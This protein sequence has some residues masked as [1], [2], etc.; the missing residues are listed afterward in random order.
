MR[1]VLRM[2][3]GID[4][5]SHVAGALT[6]RPYDRELLPEHLVGLAQLLGPQRDRLLEL[7]FVPREL[8]GA[9]PVDHR[10]LLGGRTL[11][12]GA[13]QDHRE[14][15]EGDARC[16][17]KR[18]RVVRR[19]A[20]SREGVGARHRRLHGEILAHLGDDGV[21][22][23]AAR[24][25]D[26]AAMEPDKNAPKL[27]SEGQINRRILVIDD[28]REIDEDFAKILWRDMGSTAVLAEAEA[29]RCGNRSR[30]C[31]CSRAQHG[32]HNVLQILVDLVRNAK[33]RSQLASG[34]QT[35]V[36]QSAGF[37]CSA[38]SVMYDSHGAPPTR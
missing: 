37:G 38:G 23:C 8:D 33:E 31:R 12:P 29:A 7:G 35:R 14:Q 25:Y 1:F 26:A 36:R 6:A 5:A 21:P 19:R 28:N 16:R 32:K 10:L 4:G 22:P 27:D 3:E 15:Q 24:P 13:S 9:L 17:E 11:L 30:L 2:A 34:Q 18:R 20:A